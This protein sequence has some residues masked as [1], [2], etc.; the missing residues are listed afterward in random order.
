MQTKQKKQITKNNS[1]ITLKARHKTPSFARE[2]DLSEKEVVGAP[3][4]TQEDLDRVDQYFYDH[5][6]EY[7]AAEK[8]L[9]INPKTGEPW[10]CE[11]EEELNEYFREI[12]YGDS[13]KEVY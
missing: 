13:F 1:Y 12:L 9:T 7:L 3:N 5:A 10:I 6:D 11:T 8:E 2:I 4:L